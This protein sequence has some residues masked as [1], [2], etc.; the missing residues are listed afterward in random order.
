ML[1]S[2]QKL[3]IEPCVPPARDLGLCGMQSQT[4]WSCLKIEGAPSRSS[5]KVLCGLSRD[6]N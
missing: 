5:S 6:N 3:E 2:M 4:R 1:L